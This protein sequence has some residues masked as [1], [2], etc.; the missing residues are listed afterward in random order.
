[1][2]DN[3]LSDRT[4]SLHL[5]PH[6][7]IAQGESADEDLNHVYNSANSSLDLNCKISLQY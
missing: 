1:M 7:R 3:R 4:P 2:L 6:R 5:N